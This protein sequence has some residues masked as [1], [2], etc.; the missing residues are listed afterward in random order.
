MELVQECLPSDLDNNYTAN[1][2]GLYLAEREKPT[3]VG[4]KENA[5]KGHVF[6]CSL[7][8]VALPFT[9]CVL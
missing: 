3:Q 8:R 7:E 9:I 6:G 4:V 1:G 2:L 5:H